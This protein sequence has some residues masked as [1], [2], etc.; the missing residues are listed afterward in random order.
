MANQVTVK[1]RKG[2]LVRENGQQE[3]RRNLRDWK[4][5]YG[6][7]RGKKLANPILWQRQIRKESE[8]KLP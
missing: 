7:W 3:V 4:S 5:L 8:R 1:T 6:V 2:I